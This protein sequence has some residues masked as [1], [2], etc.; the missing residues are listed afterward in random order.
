MPKADKIIVVTQK[1]KELLQSEYGVKSDR[2]AVIQNGANTDLFKPMDIRKARDELNLSQNHYYICFVGLLME[3]QGVQYLLRGIPQILGQYP[4][5]RLLIV[6]D[7][8]IKRDLVELAE[9]VGVSN[10]VIFAGSVP[11][12]TVPLYINASDVCVVPK[13][14]AIS[15]YSPLK[16]SEYMACAKPVVASRLS[17]FEVLEHARAG[18]LVEPENSPG[19]AVAITELIRNHELRKQ[20]GESGRRYIVQNQSWE[21]ATKRVVDVC[22]SLITNK[23]NREEQ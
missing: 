22:Q 21:S 9:Q 6:G 13:T 23:S 2:I 5:T 18:I 16:L 17:G 3:S 20:M 12:R 11:Y 7:G 10:K 19:L 4:E 1:L 14:P 8:P 15:G